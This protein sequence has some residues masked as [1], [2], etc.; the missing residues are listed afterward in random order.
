[1]TNN[2]RIFFIATLLI[3]ATGA[4]GYHAY[5]SFNST[6]DELLVSY[7][8]AQVARS[9]TTTAPISYTIEKIDENTS[10]QEIP[11]EESN[12][13]SSDMDMHFLFP[14]KNSDLYQG[15]TYTVSYESDTNANTAQ[16]SLV[17]SGTFKES[18]PVA[19]GLGSTIQIIENSHYFWKI[20]TVWPGKYYLYT[21]KVDNVD[22][23]IKSNSFQIHSMPSGIGKSEKQSLC[24]SSGGRLE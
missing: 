6:L 13:V 18:G 4:F 17:D 11:T 24:E 16:V 1:M 8:V 21:L 3:G 14:I 20:G 7:S 23:Q 15:C 19:S 10:V 2:T 5:Q 12:T 9:I 22:T